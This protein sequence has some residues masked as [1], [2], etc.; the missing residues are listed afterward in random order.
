MQM[1]SQHT[2]RCDIRNHPWQQAKKQEAVF[3]LA[4]PK[5]NQ[6]RSRQP[7]RVLNSKCNAIN[8]YDNGYFGVGLALQRHPQGLTRGC[9]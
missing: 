1:S 4:W 3:G 9:V 6:C 2:D 7:R 5:C 8:L